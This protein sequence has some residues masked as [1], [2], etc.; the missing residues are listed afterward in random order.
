MLGKPRIL[1]LSPNS[2]NKSQELEVRSLYHIYSLKI[3]ISRC[4]YVVM[5]RSETKLLLAIPAPVS[6][7]SAVNVATASVR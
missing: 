4:H 3:K 6:G 2:I 7:Q 5:T 1:S